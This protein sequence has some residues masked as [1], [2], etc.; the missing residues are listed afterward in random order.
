[1]SYVQ[2]KITIAIELGDDW[3]PDQRL[4]LSL[5]ISLGA[6][7]I[8]HKSGI[9]EQA[10]EVGQTDIVVIQLSLFIIKIVP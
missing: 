7:P 3:G 5:K 8:V 4:G 9:R 1:M 6:A 10:A 2:C